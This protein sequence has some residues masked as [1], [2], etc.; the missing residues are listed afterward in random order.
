MQLAMQIVAI[1]LTLY[2]LFGSRIRSQSPRQRAALRLPNC[3]SG[4]P[5][6]RNKVIGSV[7][8]VSVRGFSRCVCV[9]VCSERGYSLVRRAQ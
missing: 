6:L 2:S 4:T 9:C 1:D 8:A 3:L 7:S 5:F